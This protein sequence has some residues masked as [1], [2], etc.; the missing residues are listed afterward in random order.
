MSIALC[1]GLDLSFAG[2]TITQS[3]QPVQ[4]S[5]ATWSRYFIPLKSAAL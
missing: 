1:L 5:G 2:H 4:S 3:V